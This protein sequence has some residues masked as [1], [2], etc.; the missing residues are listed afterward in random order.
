M[1]ETSVGIIPAGSSNGYAKNICVE[2]KEELLAENCAYIIAKGQT[3]MFDLMEIESAS[4]TDKIYSFL[5]L[6]WGIISDCDVESEKMRCIGQIR[7]TLYGIYYII[8]QRNNFGSFSYVTENK[9]DKDFK[10]PSL[11]EELNPKYFTTESKNYAYFYSSVVP[12]PA[13]FMHLA[14]R[15]IPD[16]GMCDTIVNLFFLFSYI[17]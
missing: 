1:K 2:S 9:I 16:D 12:Y 4:R 17:I 15:S 8:C 11:K 7:F 6:S 5:T 10:F 3:R 14:P 13:D